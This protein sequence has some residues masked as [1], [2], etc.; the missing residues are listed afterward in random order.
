[1]H[2]R[3]KLPAS[4]NKADIY[5]HSSF[6]KFS[7]CACQVKSLREITDAETQRSLKQSE[8]NKYFVKLCLFSQ[9]SDVQ[10]EIESFFLSK[11]IL[12]DC[13]FEREISDIQKLK[14]IGI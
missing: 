13:R 7:R 10:I 4:E 2:H 5:I 1:M 3:Q 8:I 11:I 14:K 9:V 12:Y 6:S